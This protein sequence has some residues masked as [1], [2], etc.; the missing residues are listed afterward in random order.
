M[1]VSSMREQL[2]ALY[3]EKEA[4]LQRGFSDARE[5]AAQ[6]DRLESQIR[7]LNQRI[8]ETE[9]Q[10]ERI[11]A[12]TGAESVTQVIDAVQSL[13]KPPSASGG[14]ATSATSGSSPPASP[15]SSADASTDASTDRLKIDAASRFFDDDT[16][17]RLDAMTSSDLDALDAGAL[18]LAD[19]GQ[20]EA[21]NEPARS[22]LPGQNAREE[23]SLIGQ[24]FF[25]QVAPSTNN[26]L[27]FGRF[28]QG[29]EEGAMDAC[30]PY[31][32]IYPGEGPTVLIVHLYRQRDRGTNWLLFR[33]M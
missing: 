17:S 23:S 12:E 11:Q 30:F 20:I 14:A 25:L 32:F 6:I 28:K 15:S 7:T 5:A 29:V 24:N 1:I 26:N 27:F 8:T 9:R 18:R 3:E 22:L 21:A 10:L 19:D 16:L 4:L 33:P 31:T 13:Q 2:E